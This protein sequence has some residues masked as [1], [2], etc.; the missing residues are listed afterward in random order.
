MVSGTFAIVMAVAA[1][2]IGYFMGW[3]FSRE[4]NKA[5]EPKTAEEVIKREG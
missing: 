1:Y 2:G 5:D 4:S 3:L